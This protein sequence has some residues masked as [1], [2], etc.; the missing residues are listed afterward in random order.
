M[1]AP[2]KIYVKISHPISDEYTEIIGFEEREDDNDI[3]YVRTGAIL[4]WIKEQEKN[5][6]YHTVSADAYQLALDML[7]EKIKK[8]GTG[9]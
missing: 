2:D 3:E 4:E 7:K 6:K 1:K 9:R 5:L 8:N